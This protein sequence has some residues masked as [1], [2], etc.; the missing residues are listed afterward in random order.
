QNAPGGDLTG[1]P[2]VR[3][4][5]NSIPIAPKPAAPEE[6][7]IA[8]PTLAPDGGLTT[9]LGTPARATQAASAVREAQERAQQDI[10]SVARSLAEIATVLHNHAG[11]LEQFVE[12]NF[13]ND[14][15]DPRTKVLAQSLSI[16]RQADLH[17]ARLG[18]ILRR[19]G[20]AVQTAQS[21]LDALQQERERLTSLYSIAQE[22]N[23]TLDLEEVLGRVITQLIEVV[24]AERGFL[25]LWD[26]GQSHLRFMAARGADGHCLSEAD[27]T[28]SQGVVAGVWA[29]QR[30]LLTLDAQSDIRLHERESVVAYGI[31]SVM[32]APL[33]V[34]GHGVGIVY[35]DSRNQA[36]L[37]DAA[38]LDLLAAFCNQAAIAIDNAR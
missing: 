3:M 21:N 11:Q 34:R 27:F 37:F 15:V 4:H 9:Y 32:C 28:I 24:R 22:L 17:L 10:A 8:P 33:R 31:R 7:P 16:A 25:M 35:V 1:Q 38:A 26:E 13:A 23:S 30:P 6:A 20:E 18:S 12:G 36:A 5:P 2:T 19:L 29:D 14:L